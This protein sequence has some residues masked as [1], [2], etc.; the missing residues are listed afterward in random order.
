MRPTLATLFFLVLTVW[1]GHWQSSRAEYKRGL[2]ARFDAALRESPIHVGSTLLD[3]ESVL[4]RRLEV[5]G[6]FDAAHGIFID[7]RVHA[8]VAGYHVLMPFVVDG[9]RSAILVNRGWVA[10]G[11]TRAHLPVPPLPPG[12]LRLEGIATD[13]RG[14][15]FEFAGA[16]PKGRLWQNLDFDRYARAYPLPL[17]PV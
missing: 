14:R 10:A 4:Y 15:Y 8:G 17:Q 16:A 9:E 5:A 13:P 11:A 1:L 12:R 3:R 2:Q 7:N 6:H